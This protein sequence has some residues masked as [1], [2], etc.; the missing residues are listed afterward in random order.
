MH[1]HTPTHT[2]RYLHAH[3]IHAH[4]QKTKS[5][6]L[7]PV[8]KSTRKSTIFS[9][10]ACL[11]VVFSLHK[12]TKY[13]LTPKSTHVSGYATSVKISNKSLFHFGVVKAHISLAKSGTVRFG[14]ARISQLSPGNFHTESGPG[15]VGHVTQD[16]SVLVPHGVG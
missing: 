2:Y 3:R 16:E 8:A 5:T 1:I 7:E 12:T 15:L 11:L 4:T 9:K 14:H 6:H 13:F 10:P